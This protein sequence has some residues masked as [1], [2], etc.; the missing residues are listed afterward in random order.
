VTIEEGNNTIFVKAI[1]KA[2]NYRI[3]WVN[4]TYDPPKVEEP[5]KPPKER[6]GIFPMWIIFL[7][8][9]FVVG[10]ILLFFVF[11]LRAGKKKKK[12]IARPKAKERE[13]PMGFI[14]KLEKDLKEK[15]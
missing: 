9:T 7:L 6:G 5:E 2:G 3:S 1:D 8:I 14:E 12:E 15:K 13:K 11:M 10:Y 4:V